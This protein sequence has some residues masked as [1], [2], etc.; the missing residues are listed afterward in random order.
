MHPGPAEIPRGREPPKKAYHDVKAVLAQYK[1]LNGKTFGTDFCEALGI[2][3]ALL[4][5]FPG[6]NVCADG[7]PVELTID[8]L[9]WYYQSDDGSGQV[10]KMASAATE[11]ANVTGNLLPPSALPAMPARC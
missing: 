3:T 5:D 2:G 7:E 9:L 8:R 6:G 11:L 1:A 10:D 4:T